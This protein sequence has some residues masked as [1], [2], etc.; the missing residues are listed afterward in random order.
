MNK[1]PI[2]KQK[3]TK[4]N[5]LFVQEI[6]KTLQGE[7]PF[8]GAP[9]I[10]IRLAGCNLQ[11]SWC[12][13]DYS[14]SVEGWHIKAIISLLNHL[15]GTYKPLIVI[16]GG[17]PFAQNIAPLCNLLI[18]KGYSVQIETNGTL[19]VPDF[20]WSEVAVVVSPKINKLHADIA[21]EAGYFRYLIDSTTVRDSDG[22]SNNLFGKGETIAP[23]VGR[24]IFVSPL[25]NE[26]K[27]INTQAAIISCLK[28]GY[29]L[30]LQ[31]HKI[32]GV[33]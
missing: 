29:T 19:S 24:K 20:P 28:F 26:S 8:S 21:R 18:K 31:T 16:S 27:A 7:M 12:D 33:K 17:E 9:S 6:F 23:P 3:L 13:T 10:F 1:Q 11:C 2:T 22:L 25:D 15:T 5:T 32:I 30:S 14:S 4:G